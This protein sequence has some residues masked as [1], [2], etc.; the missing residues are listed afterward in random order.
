MAV[1]RQWMPAFRSRTSTVVPPRSSASPLVHHCRQGTNTLAA[2]GRMPP[3]CASMTSTTAR[4]AACSKE[5]A[6][7]ASRPV[8]PSA[9]TRDSAAAMP[10]PA[11]Q[12][13]IA[14]MTR[15]ARNFTSGSM[16]PGF[17]RQAWTC[18]SLRPSL[19][20]E[21]LGDSGGD[22][23][24]GDAPGDCSDVPEGFTDVD[25]H[26]A[27]LN[28]SPTPSAMSSRRP[29]LS[30]GPTV[31]VSQ[32]DTTEVRG[33][34]SG[35]RPAVGLFEPS[36]ECAVE[37]IFLGPDHLKGISRQQGAELRAALQRHVPGAPGKKS[38][39]VGITH[40][41]WADPRDLPRHRNVE[42][43]L[44]GDLYTGSLRTSGDH[45]NRDPLQELLV[46]PA[47]LL[48]NQS[49]LV[50]VGEQV[51]RPVDQPF[52][53]RAVQPG[54]LLGRVRDEVESPAAAFIG[55]PQHGLGVI[56]RDH[57]QIKIAATFGNRL[58]LNLA[59]LRHSAGVEGTDLGID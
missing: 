13:P 51:G 43:R 55:V 21:G 11:D 44:A 32:P 25:V 9:A 57:H 40:P 47:R 30:F 34:L 39:T 15:T 49:V 31:P 29:I 26:P 6:C 38:C 2:S 7:R 56:G 37:A 59:R 22:S 33:D 54:H 19:V 14:S 20:T 27:A 35:R 53:A 45:P 50:V 48:S 10:A 18:G 36:Q 23:A 3:Y 24:R 5:R 58:Q 42:P 28:A 41:G 17:G 8:S 12:E 46:R 16:S 52:D 1:T 4:R